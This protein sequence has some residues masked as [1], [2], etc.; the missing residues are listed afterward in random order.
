MTKM[1]SKLSQVSHQETNCLQNS[2]EAS[3]LQLQTLLVLLTRSL[4][5]AEQGKQQ[6]LQN[7]F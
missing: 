4:K 2:L 3:S 7:N 1:E 6:K 5:K